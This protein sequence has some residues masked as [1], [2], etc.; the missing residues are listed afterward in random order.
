M[1]VNPKISAAAAAGAV[2]IVLVWALGLLGID[3][4]TDVA[5]AITLIVAIAAGYVRGQG[6]WSSR[7]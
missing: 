3:V 6:S 2:T 4:P 7:V 1:N 5:S